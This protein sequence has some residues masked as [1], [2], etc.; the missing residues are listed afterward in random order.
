MSSQVAAVPVPKT[1][2]MDSWHVLKNAPQTRHSRGG[3]EVVS[4]SIQW[5]VASRTAVAV[6]AETLPAAGLK[7][8][9]D[10]A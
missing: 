8:S 5:I 3:I 6:A 7:C 2:R 1:R 10:D 9:F 4:R